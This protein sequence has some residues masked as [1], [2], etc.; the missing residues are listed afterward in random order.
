MFPEIDIDGA[1][2]SQ[3]QMDIFAKKYNKTT[4]DQKDPFESIK[5][6]KLKNLCDENGI[7]P[8]GKHDLVY[9]NAVAM[10][11]SFD[12]VKKF[13]VN[14]GKLSSQHILLIENY[15]YHD[16]P[17]LIEECLPE[18]EMCNQLGGYTPSILLKRKEL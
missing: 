15:E 14:L 3:S 13:L 6:L 5:N 10:H 16:F 12:N 2:I 4:I 7:E 1:D 9:T 17:K 18:F 8:L 11:L